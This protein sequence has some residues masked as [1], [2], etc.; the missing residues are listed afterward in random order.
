MKIFKEMVYCSSVGIRGGHRFSGVY[1]AENEQDIRK[2]RM[3][4]KSYQSGYH[5]YEEIQKEEYDRLKQSAENDLKYAK[6]H[7]E[8]FTL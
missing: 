5:N 7:L 6:R 4:E 3:K 8:L 1:I 2:N